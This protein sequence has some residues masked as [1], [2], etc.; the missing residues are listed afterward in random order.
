MATAELK[1]DVKLMIIEALRIPNV[2]PEDVDDDLPIFTNPV[3]GLDSVDALELV[4]AIQKRF[5]A[6]VDDRNLAR[7]I[8]QSV[9]SIADFVAAHGQE[10]RATP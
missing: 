7:T 9:T 5:G 1:R 2:K 6:R 10:P 3:L 4:V 8:L